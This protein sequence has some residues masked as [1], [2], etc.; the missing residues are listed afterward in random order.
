MSWT[1]SKA[2]SSGNQQNYTHMILIA[3]FMAKIKS[4]ISEKKQIFFGGLH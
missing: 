1:V 2:S 3:S 4:D